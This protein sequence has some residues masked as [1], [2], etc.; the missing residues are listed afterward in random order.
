MENRKKVK[1]KRKA[2]AFI[3][4]FFKQYT[5]CNSAVNLQNV[6]RIRM[7]IEGVLMIY[8]APP[9]PIPNIF[10]LGK[11]TVFHIPLY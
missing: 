2:L 11:A 3:V 7:Y 1:T 10:H 9:D 5:A 8:S 6:L 4:Y